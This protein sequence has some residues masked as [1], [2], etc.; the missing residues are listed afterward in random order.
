MTPAAE[1]A[2]VDD[3]PEQPRGVYCPRCNCGDLRV[4][5][6]VRLPGGRIRRYRVCRHC[7]RRLTT[8]EATLANLPR[9]GTS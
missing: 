7:G 8:V 5:T 4:E 3:Q 9:N 2:A 6:T 1:A